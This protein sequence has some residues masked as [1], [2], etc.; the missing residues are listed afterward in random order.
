[1][2]T[3]KRELAPTLRP[4]KH[5]EAQAYSE[6]KGFGVTQGTPK[7]REGSGRILAA[8]GWGCYRKPFCPFR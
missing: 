7:G 1:L 6:E 8:V 2:G 3:G 4:G 5:G